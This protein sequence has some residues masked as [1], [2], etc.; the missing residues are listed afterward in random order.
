MNIL[1]TNLFVDHNSGTE[2]FVE[3]L[4]D[5]LKRAGHNPMLYAAKLGPQ[6][7]RMRERGHVIT[8]RIETLSVRPDVIHAQHVSVALVALAAFPETPV[9]NYCHSALFQSEAPILHPNVRRHV[10]VDEHCRARCLAEGAPAERLSVLLN[11]V[12]LEKFQLRG[13][14]P[15]RPRRTPVPRAADVRASCRAAPRAEASSEAVP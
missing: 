1:I 14:L 3:T 11:P 10:A 7:E 15:K 8:D 2:T 12:D 13:P 4:A 6:A 9:L 5:G